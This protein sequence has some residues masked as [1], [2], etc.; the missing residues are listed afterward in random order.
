M[1]QVARGLWSKYEGS[2]T[3]GSEELRW[4]DAY[5]HHDH[6]IAVGGYGEASLS[7][8]GEVEEASKYAAHAKAIFEKIF[9]WL[10]DDGAWHEGAADWC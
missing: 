1:F 8:L 5:L 9:T 7:L 4:S 6:W 10:G 3:G 2:F